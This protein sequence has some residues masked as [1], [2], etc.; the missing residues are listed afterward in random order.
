MGGSDA[1][2]GHTGIL[3]RRSYGSSPAVTCPTKLPLRSI[4]R[5]MTVDRLVAAVG[6]GIPQWLQRPTSRPS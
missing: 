1:A 3:A 5:T 4:F 6:G 2:E